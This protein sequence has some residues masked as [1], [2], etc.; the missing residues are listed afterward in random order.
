MQANRPE[1]AA[2]VRIRAT[3]LMWH[4]DGGILTAWMKGLFW[5]PI[6]QYQEA[7]SA[8]IAKHKLIRE[9]HPALIPCHW[10]RIPPTTGGPKNT[11]AWPQNPH[12]LLLLLLTEWLMPETS[13]AHGLLLASARLL[14][15]P[16]LQQK[17]VSGSRSLDLP[18]TPFTA[19]LR[20]LSHTTRPAP[21]RCLP[22]IWEESLV[23]VSVPDD[24]KLALTMHQAK[25]QLEEDPS[26][27]HRSE[28]FKAPAVPAPTHIVAPNI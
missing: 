28:L 7:I 21:D 24:E 15:A 2:A 10:L 18:Q 9:T 11:V 12:G 19:E 5:Q 26:S 22:S 13:P 3:E 8:E 4:V 6:L 1:Q 17:N 25:L 20:A 27:L 14:R 23:T 16:E